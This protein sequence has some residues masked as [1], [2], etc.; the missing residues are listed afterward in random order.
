M[1]VD[2]YGV[3]TE[4]GGAWQIEGAVL[5][6]ENG[7]ELII[8]QANLQYARG[9]SKFSPLNQRKRYLATG[10]ADGV[11]TLGAV[12][13]P[14]KNIRE[15]IE[16]YSDVCNITSNVL[17]IEPAG[18]TP[19]PGETNQPLKFICQGV[20][21]NNLNIQVSQIGGSLTV[22]SAGMSFKFISMQVK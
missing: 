21:L 20:L 12:I 16:Q 11:V 22:V 18:I 6:V 13:G 14:S 3:D 9:V 10:E 19:C 8:T 5:K 7:D 1:A 15:F 2:I 17:T 4:I